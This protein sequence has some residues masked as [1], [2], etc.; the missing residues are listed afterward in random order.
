MPWDDRWGSKAD[1]QIDESMTEYEGFKVGDRV[2][3]TKDGDE[4]SGDFWFA[5]DEGEVV[6]FAPLTFTNHPSRTE[7]IVAGDDGNDPYGVKNPRH[8]RAA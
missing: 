6:G 8:I 5:G 1:Y 7:I 2:R 3:F 4:D